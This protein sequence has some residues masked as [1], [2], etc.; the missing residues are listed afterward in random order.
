VPRNLRFESAVLACMTGVVTPLSLSR[1][2][3]FRDVVVVVPRFRAVVMSRCC[4]SVFGA[5][6][7]DGSRA[8]VS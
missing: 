4:V 6:V 7:F 8:A 3:F 1:P 2:W 5:L